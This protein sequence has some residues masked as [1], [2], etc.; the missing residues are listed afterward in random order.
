MIRNLK[1]LGL[2]LVAV[3]A[4]SAMA[5]SAAQ[6][7]PELT[8][9]NGAGEHETANLS[10][11]QTSGASRDKLTVGGVALRCEV[12]TGTA[13]LATGTAT[14]VTVTPNYEECKAAGLFPSEVSVNG[15][16]YNLHNL[17]NEEG[18]YK[19]TADVLC[20]ENEITITVFN[21]AGTESICTI[22]IPEQT[23]LEYGEVANQE[24]HVELIGHFSGITAE[25]TD[26]TPESCPIPA[27]HYTNGTFVGQTTVSAQNS[28]EENLNLQ[29]TG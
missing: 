7:A 15:C 6:A 22:H 12:S 25:V 23:N 27:G 24:G 20:G 29:V 5:A 9:S 18:V 14:E 4:M 16:D 28:L 10:A 2:A 8:A 1:A 26:S 21:I 13:H 3:F 17:T 11:E 19:T